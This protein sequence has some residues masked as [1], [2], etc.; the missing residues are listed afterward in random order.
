MLMCS[1]G[2]AEYYSP[3]VRALFT[4]N[5]INHEWSNTEQQHEDCAAETI[6]NMLGLAV[7]VQLLICSMAPEFWGLA[8]MNAVHIYNCLPHSV[9]DWQVPYFAQTG[10]MPDV[11]W[12]RA[13]GCAA[14]VFQ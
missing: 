11:S 6:V 10:C 12:F 9:L 1:D 7:R 8:M 13:F 5:H 2:A 4:T 14:V 3:E